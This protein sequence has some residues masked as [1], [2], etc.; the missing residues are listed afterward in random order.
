MAEVYKHYCVLGTILGAQATWMKKAY[1][2][3]V[4]KGL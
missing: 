3:H 4:Y 1:D 2:L